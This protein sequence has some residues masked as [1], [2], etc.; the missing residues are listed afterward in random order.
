[1]GTLRKN[2]KGIPKEILEKKLKKGETTGQEKNDGIVIFKWHAASAMPFFTTK[3]TDKMAETRAR[4][5][6]RLK[7]KAIMDFSARL[8]PK[9]I[10]DFSAKTFVDV[11]D[12]MSSYSSSLRRSSDVN[13][14]AHST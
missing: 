9:A 8:K 3:Q 4:N 2:R 1:M 14:T 13:V 10:M 5:V 11:S 6:A 12:Q 7:P